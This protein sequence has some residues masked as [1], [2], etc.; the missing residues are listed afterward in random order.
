MN[1]CTPAFVPGRSLQQIQES[2]TTPTLLSSNTTNSSNSCDTTTP[3]LQAL[4]TQ[5][6]NTSSQLVP[7]FN[8]HARSLSSQLQSTMPAQLPSK[9]RRPEILSPTSRRATL[10]LLERLDA[11]QLDAQDAPESSQALAAYRQS[12]D[13]ATNPSDMPIG[14]LVSLNKPPKWGVVKISNIPYSITK[15][16]IFQFLGRKANL[17]TADQGC[18]IH[19][20]MERSTAKTMDCYV[21]F[22]TQKDASDTV[23][24]INRV[25]ENGRTPRLGN[26]HVDI[27]LTD[28]NALMKDLFPRAKCI[29][30]IDGAPCPQVNNDPYCS[31]FTG[32]F[33]GE[34]II[35]AIR[36]AEIP[37]RSPFCDKCPQ[38]TYES[39]ISTLHKFPWYATEI[40]TV[41][42]RNQLFELVNR[43]IKSLVDRMDKSNTVGLDQKLLHEL[44]HAG[45][46]C[47]A[48]NERQKY[49]LCVNSEIDTEI[50]KLPD[51][52]KWFPFDTLTRMPNFHE[53]VHH[54]FATLI[55][56]GVIPELDD[57]LE[58]MGLCNL[59]P[60]NAPYLRSPYG[61]VWFEWPQSSS[62]IT[63][64][65]AVN[66][67]MFILCSLV[68]SGWIH[69]E[70]NALNSRRVSRESSFS[71]AP[72]DRRHPSISL[73]PQK[74]DGSYA[75]T[76]ASSRS[77]IYTAPFRR[78]SESGGTGGGTNFNNA[79]DPWNQ[80]L[81]L[82]APGRARPAY[83]GHRNTKSS[84]MCFPAPSKNP[85]AL[86]G[87]E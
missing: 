33:T 19:I 2:R 25:Y 52:S 35:L 10:P 18:P 14:N 36:H 11:L 15:Q 51:M 3:G 64:N 6:S 23:I 24:Y 1:P 80:R 75:E 27:E 81:L 74:T 49:T 30:W 48:F 43:H 42:D 60:K 85:W 5:N 4:A 56:Q 58:N 22:Q 54:Y 59:F 45:L 21:E 55:S 7:R 63:W 86:Q 29:K 39:T 70:E 76:E 72:G 46:K 62:S 53:H 84:P 13:K 66:R 77:S 67:E 57:M 26:R 47:P 37:Q 20:I 61:H 44:L 31:G 87:S 32:L 38:R 78:A 82:D 83:R 50:N 28:Q 65:T 9:P 17:L 16:E 34:E 68:F 69:D 8:R 41:H 73:S 40:Y 71:L 79:G 12:I